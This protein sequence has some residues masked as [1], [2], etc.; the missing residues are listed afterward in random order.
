MWNLLNCVSAAYCQA[1]L[2]DISFDLLSDML[3]ASHAGGFRKK[4]GF[5]VP[6]SVVSFPRWFT[7]MGTVRN[8][9]LSPQ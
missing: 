9:G 7:R 5:D 6:L 2:A 3:I 4:D 1:G 8:L